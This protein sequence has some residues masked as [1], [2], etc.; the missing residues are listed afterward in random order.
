LYLLGLGLGL[1]PI[2]LLIGFGFTQCP[3]LGPMFDYQ[4]TRLSAPAFRH[5]D[6]SRVARPDARATTGPL[7][8]GL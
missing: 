5:E 7:G 4:S 3:L 6:D 2:A 1:V 8:A